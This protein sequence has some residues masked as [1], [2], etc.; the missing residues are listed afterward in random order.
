MKTSITSVT[1]TSLIATASYNARWFASLL[2]STA[3]LGSHSFAGNNDWTGT[4]DNDWDKPGNWNQGRVPSNPSPH[5]DGGFD[6]AR[7]NILTN[8][9]VIVA[10]PS[11]TSRDIMVGQGVGAIGRVDHLAGT[12]STSNGN[13]MYVGTAGGQGVYNLANPS[14][15]GGHFTGMGPSDG[16][17]N[18]GGVTGTAGRLHIGGGVGGVGTVN[19]NTTGVLTVRNDLVIGDAGGTGTFNLDAGTVTTGGWNFAGRSST[20][21]FNVSGG[22]FTNT[23]RF[24]F[25]ENGIGH[26]VQTGGTVT[27]GSE[28]WIGQGGSGLGSYTLSAGTFGVGGWFALGREGGQGTFTMTGGE[29]IKTGG[30]S[31]TLGTLGTNAKGEFNISGGLVDVQSGLFYVGEGGTTSTGILTLSG[32]GEIRTPQLI[33]GQGGS[34]TGTANLNGGTLRTG[35]IA[36]GAATAHAVF[37]GTQIVAT[38]SQAAFISNLDSAVINAGGLKVDT[39]GNSA[40]STQILSG[41]GG[42]TKSGAGTLSLLGLNTYLGDNSVEGGTL[43][44]NSESGA[45]GSFT[46][47]TG[48]GLGVSATIFDEQISPVNVTFGANTTFQV[49]FQQLSGNPGNAPMNVTGTVTLGGD[50]IVNMENDFPETGTIPLLAYGSKA[51]PGS[52]VLGSLPLGVTAT[53]VDN[54]TG[55]V[56]LNVT[57]VAMPVWEGNVNGNWDTTTQNWR[58]FVGGAPITY[59]DGNPVLFDD[60]AFGV[61]DIILNGTVLPSSVTFD[62]SFNTYSLSGSGKISGATGLTKKG[63]L[64]LSLETANDY[65][66]PTR[67]EGGITSVAT[68]PNGGVP[69]PIG[70]SAPAPANLVLA[71]GV[72]EYTG[73][74]PVTTDRGFTIGG[75]NGGI[76]TAEAVTIAGPVAS[77]P[78]G[79]FVKHGPGALTFTHVGPNVFGGAAGETPGLVI[80]QGAFVLNGSGGSQVNTAGGALFLANAAGQEASLTLAAGAELSVTGIFQSAREADSKAHLTIDNAQLNVDRF[81]LS[82]NG[83]AETVAV[84]DNA[85]SINKTGGSWISIGNTGKGTLTVKNGG[86]FNSTGGDFNISDVGTSQGFLNIES[87]GTV[88]SGGAVYIGKNGLTLPSE[89]NITGAGSSFT[90]TTTIFVGLRGTGTV[91]LA[92]GGTLNAG[93]WV[94]IGRQRANPEAAN[95]ADRPAG[96]GVINV[97]N[98]GTLNQTGG[99]G[100]IVAEGGTGTLNVNTG[101]SVAI[102]GGGLYLTAE[103]DTPGQAVVNLNSGGS[104]TARRV[105]ERDDA[106]SSTANSSIFNFNGGTLRAG[107]NAFP[108]F[109]SG[110]DQANILAG[111]AVIDSNGQDIAISQLLQGGGALTKQGAGT[112]TLSGANTYTGNTTVSAGTLSTFAL[113][114][115]SS[116]VVV[117]NGATLN[118]THGQDDLVAGLTIHG[119]V[120]ANTTLVAGSVPGLT[121]TG[122]ITV[123]TPT[124]TAYDT[125][126]SANGLSG[127]N[128]AW[129]V[130]G[131]DQD[132]VLNV[133]EYILGGNPLASDPGILPDAAVTGTHFVFTFNRSDD[134]ETDTTLNFQWGTDL[135]AW[136]NVAVGATNSTTGNVTVTVA[137]N[138]GDPDTI[139]VQV[140]RSNAPGGKLFGRLNATKP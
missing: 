13:W 96:T 69:S 133:L 115:D 44:V 79:S 99:E 119:T 60:M 1:R 55:L 100:V 104:I 109:M 101:G 48:A 89:L 81:Q 26:G 102:A 134:S 33:L 91:N 138:G 4:V 39:N 77:T 57:S 67:L 12:V 59:S 54:G 116:S 135:Q 129:N 22:T 45:T 28:V 103:G 73:N 65:T 37:N 50:V 34:A 8:Y 84:I 10:S 125:W 92:D 63:T 24:Y 95:E 35:Q 11:A 75:A 131:P 74:A 90:G 120:Y 3:M 140:P 117:A 31:I 21:F 5:P 30:G 27:N 7:V 86:S 43:V 137:E 112:L 85:G 32:T 88:S 72:L 68:L 66:G 118:L 20:G 123:G 47:A 87:G 136:N 56:Y 94:T 70:A 71:G 126:A 83:T 111:G 41:A 128:A 2:A 6:D 107:A 58:N 29:V 127:A 98:G 62:N 124:G 93:G 36:G 40:G 110:L 113:F 114:H 19:V 82:L 14:G 61:T 51:G 105:I 80:D 52:F 108:D 9:P 23:G 49:S 15:T 106:W 121:G 132:G 139:T 25:G 76:S 17:L 42:V 53:L 38:A 97:N 16:F 18:V 130:D 122:S 46:V 78:G 64:P